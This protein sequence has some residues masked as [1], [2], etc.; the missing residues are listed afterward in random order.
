M[1]KNLNKNFELCFQYFYPIVEI[2]YTIDM[3][4]TSFN[5]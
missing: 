2:I 1:E 3:R 5:Q 4:L